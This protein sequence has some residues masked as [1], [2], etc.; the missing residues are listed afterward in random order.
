MFS[1]FAKVDI[2]ILALSLTIGL[3]ALPQVHASKKDNDTI[4][5]EFEQ[6]QSEHQDLST[7]ELVDQFLVE[8]AK[9]TKPKKDEYK[10]GIVRLHEGILTITS[11]PAEGKGV[12]V[13]LPLAIEDSGEAT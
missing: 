11:T 4:V 6:Y 12:T 13:S 10:K 9:K 8:Q 3:T 1:R 7:K 2:G 5:K